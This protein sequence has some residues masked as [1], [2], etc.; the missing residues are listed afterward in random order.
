MPPPVYLLG[1]GMTP[2]AEHWEI[3]LRELA[4]QAMRQAMADAGGIRP[5]ALYVAN[6][7]SPIISGQT[8][9]G[10]L[11]ADFAGFQGIEA[12][13]VEAAGA[14]GGMALR[15]ACLA[16][17]AGAVETAMV[18]GV[19]KVTDRVGSGLDSALSAWSD[20]DYE[21]VHG[22]TATS[23]AALVMRRY[24]HEHGAPPDAL[25]GFS[26]TAHGNAVGNANAMFR[27]AISL[28][29]YRRAG[30]LSDPVNLYDAAPLAD[31]AA[32]ILLGASSV[33][34]LP[35]R[36]SVRV[37]STA[38]S[39]SRL[40]VHDQDDPLRLPAAASSAEGALAQAGISRDQVDLFEIHDSFSIYAALALEAAGY[41]QRGQGWQLARD[42]A[43][44]REGSIPVLTFGGSKARGEVGGATGVYQVAEVALQLQ[45]RG[46]VNQ[47]P[48]ARLGMAQCLGGAGATAATTILGVVDGEA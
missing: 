7:L 33:A 18:V 44:A 26:I 30:M 45:G 32:A 40:A 27:R 35:A 43:I 31:G 48:G 5:Q 37:L 25:A 34:R 29:D 39:T 4:L 19:E 14:S 15:Q 12:V 8:H 42:G 46:E 2:V 22:L 6:T 47:I 11:L 36:P 10:A 21:A 28:E 24:L 16:I 23:Q 41:A 17:E 13:T 9:L 1:I 38:A 3:S 20:A